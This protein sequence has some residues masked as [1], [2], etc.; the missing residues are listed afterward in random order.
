MGTVRGAA[1]AAEDQPP[2]F[3]FVTVDETRLRYLDCGA[4]RAVV[5]L[6][7]NGS[8]I[9]DFACSGI[10]EHAGPGLRFIAFDRPGFGYSERPRGRAW[11]PSEQASL[12][13]D[14]L[15]RLGIER[16][17]VVGH[18]WGALVALAMALEGGHEETAQVLRAGGGA[19]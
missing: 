15:A 11:G 6:H 4:G 16:P 10:M 14:A 13:L 9:E 5:L 8:M 19:Y 18:S 2:V 1:F 17:I 12:L 7:G 3:G